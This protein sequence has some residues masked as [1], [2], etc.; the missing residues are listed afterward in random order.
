MGIVTHQ[1]L[2]CFLTILWVLSA[3]IGLLLA[4]YS[5][6]Q[7]VYFVIPVDEL[8]RQFIAATSRC[9]NGELPVIYGN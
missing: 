3:R 9:L 4:F 1:G 7:L 6:R 5:L 2:A 8:V